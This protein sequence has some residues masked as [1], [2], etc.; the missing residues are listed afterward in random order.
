MGLC[1]LFNLKVLLLVMLRCLICFRSS[2][3]DLLYIRLKQESFRKYSVI[4]AS[5]ADSWFRWEQEVS[6]RI[7]FG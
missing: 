7:V 4:A 1:I 5:N 2:M 6:V 3:N